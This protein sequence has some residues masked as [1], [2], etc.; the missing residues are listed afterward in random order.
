MGQA[1]G[2]GSRPQG[3]LGR[4]HRLLG[5]G[6]QL[7]R[8]GVEV[9]LLAQPGTE[10]GHRLGGVVVAAVEAPVDQGLDAAPG[11]LALLY[12]VH[13]ALLGVLAPTDALTGIA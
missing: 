8:E 1:P 2:L 13:H 6:E 10:G 7:G 9:D 4:L 11:R 12:V 3:H 5:H